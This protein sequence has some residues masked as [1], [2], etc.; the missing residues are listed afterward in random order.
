MQ[1]GQ[2]FSGRDGISQSAVRD[3]LDLRALGG[4]LWRKKWLIIL[5]TLL[6]AGAALVAVNL[7]SPT[8]KSE[9][10]IVIEGRE[11][12]FLRPEAEKSAERTNADQ[13]AVATQVQVIQSR[14]IARRVISELKLA[15][16]PD[17]NPGASGMSP[18]SVFL[19]MLGLGRD[20]LNQSAEERAMDAY[21]SR[22]NVSAVERSRVITIEFFSGD[23]ELAARVV[24]AIVDAYLKV[25]QLAKQEQTRSAGAYLADE[26]ETL[27][28]TAAEA[29]AKVED[30]RAKANLF[31]GSNNNNLAN[32]QL[33]ELTTQLATARA[34]KAELDAKSRIIRDML[35]N[36]RS[37]E[38]ADIVNSDL[39]KRLVEQRVLL[40]AQLAEQSSTLLQLHPRIQELNAQINALDTQMR[41][42]LQ[43]L[44]L[45]LE[46]DARI[47]NAR[48]ET[49]NDG[50]ERLKKQ[51]GGSSGQD[52]QLRALEREA[53]AQR[54]LLETYLARYRETLARDNIGASAAEARLISRATVS[55]VPAFPKKLPI[56]IIA[57]LATA[58]LAA[59]FVVSSEILN[60]SSPRP[61]IPAQSETPSGTGR[62][63][64]FSA[65]RR[66]SAGAEP[67]QAVA[68][69]SPV[70]DLTRTLLELGEAGRRVAV[71]GA[72]RNVGTTSLAIGLARGLSAQGGRVV[73]AELAFGAPNLSVIAVDPH[74][75]G[76]AE[77]VR[78]TV[79][80]GDIV[81]RD[82]FS[83]VHVV[84]AGNISGDADAILSSPRLATTLEALARTYDYVVIDA[85]AMTGVQIAPIAG[86]ASRAV[87]VTTDEADPATRALQE[88]L[89]AA[90]LTDVTVV[91]GM[92]EPAAT[93]S[94]AA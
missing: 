69:G 82:K 18:I 57:A 30:F 21:F 58:F 86:I 50:L 1:S 74:A 22:L 55:N 41:G 2:S 6:V 67:V 27:R 13:E 80:F 8:Y 38:S 26:I 84:S 81:T 12:V 52:V 16:R 90:G 49:T 54:D 34:Q 33:G 17:F 77:L 23:P 60:Q 87:L 91:R 40:R 78:G 93:Q 85:G 79:S 76:F 44:V 20:S 46:N 73:L 5:P 62:V 88:Q 36:G 4:S 15:E 35:K 59:A 24:N 37:V 48:I 64:M 70:E 66:K 47:A 42:E 11:N 14:D 7:M 92:R 3:E 28:K 56:V 51:V 71:V 29:D 31:V 94:A 9:A 10:K 43:R 19:S 68:A 72:A 75:P 32:Q 65:L 63:S 25:Q 89:I 45:S 53:K 83:P 39:L 61:F